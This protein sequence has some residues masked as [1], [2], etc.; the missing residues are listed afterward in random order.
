MRD[1]QRSWNAVRPERAKC[2]RPESVHVYAL[3]R[4]LVRPGRRTT[5]GMCVSSKATTGAFG[6]FARSHSAEG[7]SA[8]Y[9]H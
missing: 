1:A 6:V 2:S 7:I 3:T 4:I 5:F 9:F 8:S